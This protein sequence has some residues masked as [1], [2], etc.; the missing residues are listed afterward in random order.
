[1][2]T[3]HDWKLHPD[4]RRLAVGVFDFGF[5]ERGLFDRRP[6]YGFAATDQ[7]AAHRDFQELVHRRS[8][9]RIRHGQVGVV[10][11]A[12]DAEAFEL[13]ALH[14]DPFLGVG[15][16]GLTE[17]ARGHVA[18]LFVVGAIVFLDLPFDGQAVTVPAGDVVGVEPGHLART[19]HKVLE[20]LVHRRADVDVA[21]RV[22]RTIME[23]ELRAAL[24]ILA[25]LFVELAV[26]PGFQPGGFLL[27]QAAP[28]GEVR[29]RKK[30][31]VLVGVRCLG[32]VFGHVGFSGRRLGLDTGAD[33]TFPAA[34]PS[35]RAPGP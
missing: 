21:V 9:R 17:L 7:L 23:H 5:G 1:M 14:V 33:T 27:W 32:R 24:R 4:H 12:H 18:L 30:Q 28:H 8:F 16:A 6:H 20:D 22:G 13:G 3:G 29:L 10:P 15:A 19:H 11:V 31:R 2:C 25:E 34:A 26:F 35:Q